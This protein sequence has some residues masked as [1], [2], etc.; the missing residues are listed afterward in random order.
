METF[1]KDLR[2]HA[3]KIINYEKKKEMIQLT[4]EE[5]KSF[6]EQ[7][8]CYICKKEF[9]DDD[10]DDDNDDNNKK[11]QKERDHCITL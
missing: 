5:N 3:M 9:S 4:D 8:I 10:H 2:E 11:Y 7:N 6:E 1:C